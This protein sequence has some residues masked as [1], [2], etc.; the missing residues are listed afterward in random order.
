MNERTLPSLKLND[1]FSKTW[2]VYTKNF[3]NILMV[4]LIVYIPV[5]ALLF[6]VSSNDTLFDSVVPFNRMAQV[7]KVLIGI[8]PTFALIFITAKTMD[9]EIFDFK[10]VLSLAV[11]KWGRGICTALYQSVI[12]IALLF[13]LVVP[14]LI[15]I[16]YYSFTYQAVA[17]RDLKNKEALDYSK[18]LVKG[19]WWATLGFSSAVILAPAVLGMVLPYTVNYITDSYRGLEPVK[20]AVD[21]VINMIN[22]FSTVGMTILFFEIER[23]K[24]QSPP[25]PLT[26]DKF[27]SFIHRGSIIDDA[28][29]EE[30]IEGPDID[31]ED[32]N[33][34]YCSVCGIKVTLDTVICPMCHSVIKIQKFY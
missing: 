11:K 10:A 6:L 8:I 28:P 31:A 21:V 23:M 13:L 34:T 32:K 15:W 18:Y 24:A 7:L 25:E 29:D 2:E 12:I 14:G 4:V 3:T 9:G 33:A 19:N 5:N 1:I 22:A 27:N 26:Y 17:L 16:V 30:S 20:I